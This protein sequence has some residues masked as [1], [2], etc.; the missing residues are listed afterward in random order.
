M[1]VCSSRCRRAACGVR[2][3]TGACRRAA[4]GVGVRSAGC[5]RAAR[6]VGVRSRARGRRRD[7]VRV[8]RD[9]GVRRSSG[10]TGGV[11]RPGGEEELILYLHPRAAEH[12]AGVGGV[13][14]DVDRAHRIEEAAQRL[15]VQRVLHGGVDVLYGRLA[16]GD[17]GVERRRLGRGGLDRA[18]ERRVLRRGLGDK[19]LGVVHRVDGLL[20]PRDGGVPCAYDLGLD[21]VVL[22]VV[23]VDLR[24]GRDDRRPHV[25]PVDR[26]LYLV[27]V[28]RDVSRHLAHRLPRPSRRSAPPSWRCAAAAPPRERP[29]SRGR[30]CIPEGRISRRPR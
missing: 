21:G 16:L 9:D 18:R 2:V 29:E 27:H 6:G 30:G 10:G 11:L 28:A 4:H 20:A 12:G 15:R 7:G 19:R 8:F 22:V 25:A 26:V 14:A 17:G 13:H 3:R 23:V 1:G 24:D 5:R